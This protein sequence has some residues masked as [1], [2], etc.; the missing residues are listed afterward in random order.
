MNI[1][2]QSVFRATAR[3]TGAKTVSYGIG[4]LSTI[5]LAWILMPADFGI[6]ALAMA[7][8]TSVVLELPVTLALI[9]MDNPTDEDFNTAWTL[10]ILRAFAISVVLLL[11]AHP[12]AQFF[13]M[14]DV[15]N[16]IIVL[17][18]QPVIFAQE[19]NVGDL[20]TVFHYTSMMII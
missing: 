19:D 20:K 7:V 12:I 6:I 17:A 13:H 2:R 14:L 8:V 9:Q 10:S 3:L 16:V 15:G 5:V 18:I 4:F 11:T 1:S